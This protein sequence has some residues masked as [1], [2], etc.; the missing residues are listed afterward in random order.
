MEKDKIQALIVDYLNGTMDSEQADNFRA[1]LD[2]NGYD[3][4]DFSELEEVYGRLEHNPVPEPGE[5]M[6]AGSFPR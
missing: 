1:F 4:D 6:H 3:L 2:E 5:S